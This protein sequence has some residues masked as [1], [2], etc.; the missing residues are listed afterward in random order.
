MKTYEITKTNIDIFKNNFND[1]FTINWICKD[2]GFGELTFYND[3]AGWQCDTEDMNKDFA[4]AVL[5]H[6]F[7][8]QVKYK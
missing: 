4:N 2:I 8:T 6:F 1:G 3:G 5:K 7:D